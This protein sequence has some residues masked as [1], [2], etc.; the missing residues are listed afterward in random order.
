MSSPF[1]PHGVTFTPVSTALIKTRLIS[2][3]IWLVIPGVVFAVLGYMLSPW[4]YIGTAITVP[5]ALWLIFLIGRQVRAM[6]WA[7]GDSEFMIR[8]GVLFKELTVIPYG[9]IQ[10]VDINEGPVARHYG[11]STITLHTASPH[12]AGSLEGVPSAE[13]ARLR[14][15]LAER[16]SAEMAGL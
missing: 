3:V 9:R 1:A 6:G 5:L 7:E 2:T 11:I 13:A 16:G 4:F 15:L 14:D 8:K 12:T 10:Y